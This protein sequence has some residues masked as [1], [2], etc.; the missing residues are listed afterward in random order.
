M[1]VPCQPNVNVKT[2]E[3]M[4]NTDVS[5]ITDGLDLNNLVIKIT[6][7]FSVKLYKTKLTKKLFSLKNA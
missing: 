6:L 3:K 5:T 1:P 4:N 7:I 2:S